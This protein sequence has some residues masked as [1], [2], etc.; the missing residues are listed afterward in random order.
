MS[1]VWGFLGALA[2]LAV[3][4]GGVFT[5]W[6]LRGAAVRG[7]VEQPGESER[8]RLKEEQEAF[9]RVQNYTVEDAYGMN[10]AVPSGGGTERDGG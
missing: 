10:A 3:F 1:A 9:R 2:A 5:G 6:R 4:G 7:R 8:R